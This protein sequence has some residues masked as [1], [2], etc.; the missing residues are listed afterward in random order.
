MCDEK[1]EKVVSVS[2]EGQI[3]IPK[4]MREKLKIDTQGRIKFVWTDKGDIIIRPIYSEEDFRD[5]VHEKSNQKRDLPLER[6]EED[7]RRDKAS[8][9]ELW[10][11]YASEF[12]L[13]SE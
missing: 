8:N 13:P 10:G 9:E 2:A 1:L 3:T 4:E 5:S 6:L 12:Y 11:R 7:Y